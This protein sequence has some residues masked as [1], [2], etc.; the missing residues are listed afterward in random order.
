METI[1]I[2]LAGAKNLQD[3]RLKLKALANAQSFRY[4]RDGKSVSI[5]MSSYEDFGDRQSVYDD[6]IRNEADVVIF[7]FDGRI[8]EKTEAEIRLA[9]ETLRRRHR[10]EI[11]TFVRTSAERT[12]DMERLERVLN[13][14]SD[15]YYVDFATTDE[16]LSK[17][18][19]RI[20][21]FVDRRLAESAIGRQPSG[22]PGRQT[23]MFRI[24]TGMCAWSYVVSGVAWM[25]FYS[26]VGHPLGWPMR[27]YLAG[28]LLLPICWIVVGSLVGRH[29]AVYAQQ[30]G[31]R[32]AD[33]ADLRQF[34]ADLR[35][36]AAQCESAENARRWKQLIAEA[37]SVPPRQFAERRA[38]LQ[39]RAERLATS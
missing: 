1:K 8:G 34:V 21:L 5:N 35:R 26:L 28:I 36:R 19:D 3:E 13:E 27:L 39:A 23:P 10:P 24:F 32:E 12:P 33:T 18:R 25:L 37:E 14:V 30:Q 9:H 16:L 11:H 2:F 22:E 29:D 15:T 17:A 31:G 6:F 7:L 4:C 20:C 38:D